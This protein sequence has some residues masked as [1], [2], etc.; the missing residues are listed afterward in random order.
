M[1]RFD[2][3]ELFDLTRGSEVAFPLTALRGDNAKV[4]L[5]WT[6]DGADRESSQL[7]RIS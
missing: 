3:P 1:F 5:R 2:T 7:V 6:E 4:S